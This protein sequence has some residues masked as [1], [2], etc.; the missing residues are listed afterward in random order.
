MLQFLENWLRSFANEATDKA[1][2]RLIKDQYIENLFELVPT[3][4]KLILLI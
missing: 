2:N 3:A 4:K 1:L